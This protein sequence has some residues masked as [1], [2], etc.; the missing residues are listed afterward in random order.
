MNEKVVLVDLFGNKVGEIEKMEAHKK[1]KLH[2]AFSLF[3][4]KDNKM[5]IQKRAKNKYH[6]GGLWS[7]ACCSHP[8]MFENIFKNIKNKTRQELGAEILNLKYEF[9]FIYKNKFKNNLIEYEYDD[10][11]S[12]EINSELNI[13]KN[14]I[15]CVKWLELNILKKELENNSEKFTSWFLICAPK[16]I[17]KYLNN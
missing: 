1:G 17:E 6:S 9:S 12:A 2:H 16:I 5:L 3:I 13:N 14:E 7:N 15:E 4:I 10:V 11:F 8:Q